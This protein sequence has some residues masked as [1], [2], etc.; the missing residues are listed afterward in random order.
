MHLN[1]FEFQSIVIIVLIKAPVG[2]IFSQVEPRVPYESHACTEQS[3]QT[4]RVHFISPKLE[5]ATLETA[6]VF[7]SRQDFQTIVWVLRMLV[8]SRLLIV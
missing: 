1:I 8:A 6:T 3:L 5:V 7:L 2:T 4:S